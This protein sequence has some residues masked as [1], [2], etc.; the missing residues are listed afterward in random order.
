M[1]GEREGGMGVGREGRGEGKEERSEQV[2]KVPLRRRRRRRRAE[3]ESVTV[4]LV[5][6]RCEGDVR[7]GAWRPSSCLGFRKT[8]RGCV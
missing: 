5:G 3:G 6:T 8:W 4:I 2:G 1:G 7:R